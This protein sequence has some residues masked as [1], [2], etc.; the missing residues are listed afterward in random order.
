MEKVENLN[1]THKSLWKSKN[2]DTVKVLSN[3]FLSILYPHVISLLKKLIVGLPGVLQSN[4][5]PK[6]LYF[7]LIS[8]KKRK[9][10]AF[11]ITQHYSTGETA[12][13]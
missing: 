12:Y 3:F 10:T 7:F 9:E 5:T 4:S 13:L 1:F 2:A 11:K 8:Y 6:H